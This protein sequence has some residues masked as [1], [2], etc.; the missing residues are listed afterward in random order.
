MATRTHDDLDARS[1]GDQM[2]QAADSQRWGYPACS[3]FYRS[4]LSIQGLWLAHT[5]LLLFFDFPN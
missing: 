2:V 1:L 4:P 5:A 3:D